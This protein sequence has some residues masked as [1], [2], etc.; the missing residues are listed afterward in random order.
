M[1]ASEKWIAQQLLVGVTFFLQV[2]V[3]VEEVYEDLPDIMT[4]CRNQSGRRA[5]MSLVEL[6]W[7]SRQDKI[8]YLKK[9]WLQNSR[10]ISWFILI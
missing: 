3:Q 7:R 8:A 2:E 5:N 9:G 10:L 4:C 1:V 6:D